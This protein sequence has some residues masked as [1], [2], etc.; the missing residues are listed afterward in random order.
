M[1][2]SKISVMIVDDSSTASRI[3]TDIIN[4]HPQM[5]VVAA[6]ADPFEAVPKLK[7]KSP[8]VMILDVQMPRMDGITFLKSS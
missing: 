2:S 6:V 3:L 5:E 4:R 7:R 1:S 8:D